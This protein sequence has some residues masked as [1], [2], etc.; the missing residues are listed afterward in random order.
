MTGYPCTASVTYGG[1][2]CAFLAGHPGPCAPAAKDERSCGCGRRRILGRGGIVVCP[3][4]D[5]PAGMQR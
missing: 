3:A 1:S 5:F 2:P 4:C